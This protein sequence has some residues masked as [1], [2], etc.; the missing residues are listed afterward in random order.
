MGTSPFPGQLILFQW[1][2]CS[3]KLGGKWRFQLNIRKIVWGSLKTNH[4]MLSYLLKTTNFFS[5]FN[6]LFTKLFIS[7]HLVEML[8]S[9]PL[10]QRKGQFPTF[11]R[12]ES[13]STWKIIDSQPARGGIWPIAIT[14]TATFWQET[15]IHSQVHFLQCMRGNPSKQNYLPGV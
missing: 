8:W 4:N 15:S 3:I 12:R 11:H 1:G 5:T 9:S 13:W 7:D 2:E 10:F 14:P 6:I